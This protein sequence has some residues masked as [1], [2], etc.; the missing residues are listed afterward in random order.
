MKAYI[1]ERLLEIGTEFIAKVREQLE[2]QG[3]NASGRLSESLTIEESDTGIRILAN[4]YLQY[5]EVGR[6]N[7]RVPTDFVSILEQWIKDKN[8]TPINGDVHEFAESIKWKT[9]KYG[10][11]KFRGDRPKNDVLSESYKD[12]DSKLD[13][14]GADIVF[15]INDTLNL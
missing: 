6:K 2:S 13:D 15:Y 4:D 14:L 7:G 1:K 9:I 11:S 8:L 3:V 10:S 5:A 12:L